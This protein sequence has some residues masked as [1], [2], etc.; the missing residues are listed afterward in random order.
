MTHVHGDEFSK[1]QCTYDC[2]YRVKHYSEPSNNFFAI[3]ASSSSYKILL[4][5]PM[6]KEEE[7]KNCSRMTTEISKECLEREFSSP[8]WPY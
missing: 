8:S 1:I 5:L 2:M 7:L 6:A 4:Y 3:D